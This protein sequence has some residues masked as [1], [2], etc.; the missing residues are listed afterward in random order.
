M[1]IYILIQIA[2]LFF[3][4][5]M[6]IAIQKLFKN[7]LIKRVMQGL[8]TLSALFFSIFLWILKFL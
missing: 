5:F 7:K 6:I 8:T 2:I 1:Y 3:A 4:G